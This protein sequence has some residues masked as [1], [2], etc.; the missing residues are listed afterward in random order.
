MPKYIEKALHKFQHTKPTKPQWSPH[1]ATPYIPATKGQHQY[2]PTP[3]T[4]ALLNKQ[5]TTLVQSIVGTLLYYGRVINNTILP[6]LNTIASDQAQPTTTTMRK[7]R[8]LL[9]YV[10]TYP[11]VFIRY[12]ASDMVLTINSDAAY[13]VQP[14]ARSQLQDSFS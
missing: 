8:R 1:E 5:D 9:D 11:D 10:A 6:A 3:D 14:Q 4:T 7:Y 13:L 12:H 2:A